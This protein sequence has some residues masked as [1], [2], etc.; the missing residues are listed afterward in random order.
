MKQFDMTFDSEDVLNLFDF[1]SFLAKE[2]D[3]ATKTEVRH[4]LFRSMLSSR[5]TD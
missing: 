3:D 4:A 2:P 1:D 5:D